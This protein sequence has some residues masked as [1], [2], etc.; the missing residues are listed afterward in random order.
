MSNDQWNEDKM[1]TTLRNM[2]KVSDHR[3]KEEILQ[4]LKNDPRLREEFQLEK[5]QKKP[6]WLPVLAAVAAVLLLS[7]LVPTFLK[8]SSQVSMDKATNESS[9]MDDA[10]LDNSAQRAQSESAESNMADQAATFS[11]GA[12]ETPHYAVYPNDVIDHQAFHI[13]LATNQATIVPVTFLIPKEQAEADLHTEKPDAV[14]LY[15][16]YAGEIDEESLGFTS[17][18]P[19]NADVSSNGNQILM[20]LSDDHS[21]D[22]GSAAL[23]MLNLS[24][25]DTFYG[26]DEVQFLKKDDSPVTFDQVGKAGKPVKLTSAQK[27]QAYYRF[28]Q[29]NGEELLSSNF[30]KSFDTAKQALKAMKENPNDLYS[31]VIPQGIDFTVTEDKKTV[32]VRFA[33]PTDLE[34][35]EIEDAMQMIEGILLTAASFDQQVEFEQLVQEQW[36]DFDFTKPLPKPVGANPKFL[37]LQ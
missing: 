22:I 33:K 19:Y 21:Y 24:V 4:Q 11:R 25:Q 14:A 17:Y 30:G 23:E 16:Q 36:I 27:Q 20:K 7:I 35:L 32:L 1:K 18:H 28:T 9:K 13:G 3:S 31:S 8:Q 12:P 2:P 10:A 29:E 34:G 15:N 6:K 5:K 37:I 26:F